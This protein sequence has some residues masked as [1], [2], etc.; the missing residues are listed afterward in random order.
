MSGPGVL[1]ALEDIGRVVQN[2]LCFNP[3]N[4]SRDNVDDALVG[5]P[6]EAVRQFFALLE[7]RQISF[8][9][10]GGIAWLYYVEGRNTQDLDL[11][12]ATEDLK[13]LP[14]VEIV[15]QDLYFARGKFRGL[16]ADFLLTTNPLF[17]RVRQEYVTQAHL[18]DREVPIATVEGLLLLKLYALPSL[19]RQGNFGRVN[20]YESDIAALVYHYE[21]EMAPLLDIVAEYVGEGDVTSLRQIVAEIEERTRR[22]KRG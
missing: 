16:Q 17:R 20:V 9:L 11:V 13:R 3:R 1:H 12:V 15:E 10:V 5:S 7:E 22:F 14:E 2:A 18:L 8:V 4:W 6:I 19:Y 21:P